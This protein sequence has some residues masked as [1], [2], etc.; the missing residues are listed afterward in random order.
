MIPASLLLIV[1]PLVAIAPAYVLRRWRLVEALVAAIACALAALIL[2][3]S[4]DGAFNIAGLTINAASPVNVLGRTLAVRS[5][6]QMPLILLFSIAALLF[7][8]GWIVSEDWTY[9]PVGLGILALLTA[10]LLIRPFLFAG[11]AFVAA[12]ALG[13]IMAQGE[14]GSQ[15][16]GALRYLVVNTLALPAFLGASY[17]ITQASNISDV[18]AQAAAYVPAVTLLTI[19]LALIFGAFPLYTWTH[20]VTK[21]APPM[22]VAFLATVVS[23]AACFLFLSLAQDFSW[24]RD[25]VEMARILKI[26]G[27]ATL[28]LGGLLGWAQRSFGR[29]IACGIS[30]EIGGMLI[31][32][33]QGQP[34]SRW[35]H[36]PFRS[37]RA[38]YRWACWG[39]ASNC[40][41][42]PPGAIN[43]PHSPAMAASTCG[44]PSPLRQAGSR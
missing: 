42:V 14:R 38:H 31:L 24:F 29:V 33:T 27:I 4:A 32:L 21:E 34:R 11:L 41:N 12:A 43:L 15:T 1:I 28:V 35:R 19:G 20:Q 5:T 16:D 9:V 39:W 7:L 6:D 25:S 37:W 22:A 13:A 36:S 18:T 23:G 2:A 40:C 30:V 44:P 26:L 8:L 3:R 10:G 17:V